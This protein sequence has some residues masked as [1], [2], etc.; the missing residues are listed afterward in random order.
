[1]ELRL[2]EIWAHLQ[3]V[4]SAKIY[5]DVFHVLRRANAMLMLM[6]GQAVQALNHCSQEWS[7]GSLDWA[8]F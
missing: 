7:R 6:K 5:E 3:N 4:A 8:L 1:M 2:L